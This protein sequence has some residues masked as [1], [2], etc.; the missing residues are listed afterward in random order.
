MGELNADRR[1]QSS[2][3]IAFRVALHLG[4]FTY[5]AVGPGAPLHHVALGVTIDELFALEALGK[6]L[7]LPLLTS[8]AFAR[9]AASDELSSI[10]H[11]N[12]LRD[13]GSDELFSLRAFAGHGSGRPSAHP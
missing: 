5:G 11:H 12:L 2:D 4:V 7:T 13:G 8:S 6:R 1:M 9:S 3:A 10:G